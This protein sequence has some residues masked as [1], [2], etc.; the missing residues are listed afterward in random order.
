MIQRLLDISALEYSNPVSPGS[1]GA[2]SD[3]AFPTQFDCAAK[4]APGSASA[5]AARSEKFG[6]YVPAFFRLK[7]TEEVGENI[8]TVW[9]RQGGYC[10]GCRCAM[11]RLALRRRIMEV[12]RLSYS[13]TLVRQES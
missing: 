2:S 5:K 10:R 9:T 7:T 3:L 12:S 6:K 13:D 4:L 1:T 11:D 8:V